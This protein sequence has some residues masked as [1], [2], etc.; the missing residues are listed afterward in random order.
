MKT[1][2]ECTLLDLLQCVNNVTATDQEATAVVVRLINS[3]RVRLCGTF[4]GAKIPLPH[5]LA[6]FPKALWP[7]LA[8]QEGSCDN[9]QEGSLVLVK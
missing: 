6:S 3:G 2:I 1:P 7:T 5:T 9:R 8:R 4:A